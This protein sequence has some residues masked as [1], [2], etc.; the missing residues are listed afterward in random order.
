[1]QQSQIT[2]PNVVKVDFDILPA[3]AVVYQIQAFCHV[4][5][6]TDGEDLVVGG[7]DTVVILPCEQVDAH[8]A[9]DEPED[10]ADQQHIHDG[11][12]G[13]QQSVHHNLERSKHTDKLSTL[14]PVMLMS[15]LSKIERLFDLDKWQLHLIT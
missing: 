3:G 13:P 8:D 5:D 2:G 4:V 12:D 9:E 14:L 10:E 7:V 15:L 11:G 1:M 6:D